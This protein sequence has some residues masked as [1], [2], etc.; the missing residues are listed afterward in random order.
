[1]PDVPPRGTASTLAARRRRRG[2]E[3]TRLPVPASFGAEGVAVVTA[4]GIALLLLAVLVAMSVGGVPERLAEPVPGDTDVVEAVADGGAGADSPRPDAT[5]AAPAHDDGFDDE[6]LTPPGPEA[7]D[8]GIPPAV[9]AD[10]VGEVVPQPR[11]PTDEDAAEF[12][13]RYEPHGA[14]ERQH[15][16]ADVTGDGRD[17]IVVASVA[18]RRAR[19]DIAVWDGFRYQVVFAAFGG[20]AARLD[21][22]QVQDLTGDGAPEI[23]TVQSLPDVRRSLS[24]WG[25]DGSRFT[26]RLGQGGCWHGSNTFGADGASVTEGEILATCDGRPLPRDSWPSDVYA[27]DGSDWVHERT[28]RP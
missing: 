17:E 6:A 28:D 22:F 7:P 1:V 23:V 3:R 24:V 2:G 12:T 21:D 16:A 5:P 9:P 27:W 10:D 11:A 4:G 19:I 18:D 14:T 25:W 26:P 15:V 8:P 20:P 13:G